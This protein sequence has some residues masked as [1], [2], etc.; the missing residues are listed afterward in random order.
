VRPPPVC[1]DVYSL[2]MMPSHSR[3]ADT[4]GTLIIP[5]NWFF[6]YGVLHKSFIGTDNLTVNNLATIQARS[7]IIILS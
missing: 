4:R 5:Q 6:A 7:S 3:K 2:R 1:R